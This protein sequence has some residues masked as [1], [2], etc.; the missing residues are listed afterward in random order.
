MDQ[1]RLSRDSLAIKLYTM[2]V[3][4]VSNFVN[5]RLDASARNDSDDSV[6]ENWIGI[7]DF[8][9]FEDHNVV[10]GRNGINGTGNRFW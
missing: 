6:F 5:G 1:C 3:Q 10:P 7:L 2:L 9:G 4:L 8:A